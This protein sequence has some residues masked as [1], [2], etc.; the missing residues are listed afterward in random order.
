MQKTHSSVATVIVVFL[1]LIINVIAFNWTAKFFRNRYGLVLL[2]YGQQI[3]K[4]E[5]RGYSA[6]QTVFVSVTKPTLVLYLTGSG[7]KGQSIALL[8][9]CESL[10]KQ[11]E[12]LF[13]TTIITSGLLPEI[14][15]LLH[16]DLIT[17][18][19]INDAEG[20]LARRLGL[21]SGESGTFFFD[22]SGVCRFATRQQANPNDLRQLLATF[23]TAS[24]AGNDSADRPPLTKEKPLPS[25]SLLDA[26]SRQRVTTEQ[27]LRTDDQVWIFFVADCF[28]CGAPAPS[29]YLTQFKYWRQAAKDLRTEPIIV[30][31][32]AFLRH[33]VKAELERFAINS[34]AYVSNED[35]SA[36]S[37]FLLAQGRRT[38]QPLIV[39]TNRLHVV[40]S[41]G[42]IEPPSTSS[43][44][45]PDNGAAKKETAPYTRIFQDLGLDVYDVASH[46]GLYYVS[47]RTRNSIVVVNE[48][49]EIQRVIGGIG[50]APG[51][52]F[53][54]GYVDVSPEGLIYVQDGGN[55]RIQ[56]FALDGAYLGGFTTKPYTGMAAGLNGE[57]YLGQPENGA[58]VSVYSRDGKRL[59]SFGKL[60]TYSQ[61]VGQEIEDLDEQYALAANRVRL[62]VN[63]DGSTLVSFMLVPL[64]QK[65]SPDGKLVFESRLEGPEIDALRQTPGLLTMSMDGV[66]E[67]ILAL[68]AIALPHGEID[69]VLTNGSI[70]VAD[71][72]GRRRRVI[73]PQTERSFTP[74]MTGLTPTGALLVIGLNPRN[75][76]RVSEI[77]ASA[78]VR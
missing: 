57:I 78:G 71:E 54:P 39:R 31:D 6:D 60:K 20:Q 68:E 51:R 74:E 27:L 19:I 56:C 40:E 17:H 66:P 28:V 70:Y 30:F 7:I 65:Y 64:V 15:Q 63:R 10:S 76:Y 43:S 2:Q 67:T 4:L 8:K 69:V 53:R 61:L 16:D 33:D 9:F 35:L 46:N 26:R 34:P 3:P 25:F 11:R 24:Y 58:L 29:H 22:Q 14:Q 75:C 50:S 5:G 73:Q 72:N 42:L 13:E 49:F 55:E 47:D 37:H 77:T 18:S 44:D 52:L 38:D 32:S 12:S 36:L 1:L 45:Q 59:R 21:E 48:R 41:I 62:S 23:V